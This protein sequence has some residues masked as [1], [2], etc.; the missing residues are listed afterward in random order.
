[1]SAPSAQSARGRAPSV[2]PARAVA[3]TVLRR[4]FEH[5]AYADR[6]F[7]A[8]ARELSPRDRALAMQLAYGAVQRRATLDHFAAE[9]SGRSVARIDS[10]VLAALRLGLYQ[11]AFLAGVADHAAVNESVELAKHASRGGASLV[12]AVLRRAAR[13]SPA[14]LAGLSDGTAGEAAIMHSVPAWLAE[15]W[16]AELGPSDARAL[17]R[18]V[19]APAESAL[20][21]NALVLDREAVIA[22][23]TR[24][25]TRRLGAARGDCAR[26]AVRRPRLRAVARGGDHAPVARIDA[27]RPGTR[28]GGRASACWTCALRPAR[29]RPTWRR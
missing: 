28:A 7:T 15:Q 17:L 29:R 19:N 1:M 10:P 2:S 11:L 22:R 4:V 14:L 12:N 13:E 6:A 24:A 20:R 16:F 9:L 3:F 18:T 8:E 27:R 26:G 23:A 21:A 5:G 25:R